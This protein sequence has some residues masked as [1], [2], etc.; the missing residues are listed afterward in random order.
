MR[1]LKYNIKQFGSAKN[2][3]LYIT[4]HSGAGKSTLSKK[5]QKT[6]DSI[7]YLNLDIFFVAAKATKE[8]TIAYINNLSIGHRLKTLLLEWFNS[9]A[10]SAFGYYKPPKMD[11]DKFVILSKYANEFVKWIEPYLTKSVLKYIFES[12]TL[13]MMEPSFF[14][15]KAMILLGTSYWKASWRG[16]KR[17]I[18]RRTSFKN[19]CNIFYNR[20][21]TMFSKK[22]S[23]YKQ[24]K[25]YN[26]FRK[27]IIEL[28]KDH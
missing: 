18:K 9:Q 15:D 24:S 2:K 1:T 21:L 20:I 13:Y 5:L 25:D 7:D 11:Y 8:E 14:K 22:N 4:G 10:E 27:S 23:L 16:V 17:A 28:M 3:I 12:T 26:K 6:S 19:F